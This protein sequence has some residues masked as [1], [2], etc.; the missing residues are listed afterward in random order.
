MAENKTVFAVGRIPVYYSYTIF[1]AHFANKTLGGIYTVV[2]TGYIKFVPGY[3]I[4][5]SGCCKKG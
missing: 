1:S 4:G 5:N 3:Q 2:K